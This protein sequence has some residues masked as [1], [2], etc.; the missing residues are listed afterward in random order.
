[1]PSWQEISD[2]ERWAVVQYLKTFSDRWARQ[3]V[4]EP[5]SVPSEPP[6]APAS[7]EKGKELFQSNCAICHGPAGKADGPLAQPGLLQDHWGGPIK[8]AHL[9]LPAGV[10]GGVKLGHE[11]ARLFYTVMTGVGGTPMP[12]FDSMAAGEVWDV[13]HYVQ[14]LRVAA[15]E[16]ELIA[17]GLQEQDLKIARERIW[18]SMSNRGA[19]GKTGKA[20]AYGHQQR[21]PPVPVIASHEH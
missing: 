2:R 21:Q 7:I 17:A 10:P 19:E 14:S 12:P 6:V 5:V 11:G 3:S 16:T 1:M 20:I 15:H 8:P 4:G 13:V 18:I 9:S